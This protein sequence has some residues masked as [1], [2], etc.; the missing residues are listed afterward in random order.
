LTGYLV[1]GCGVVVG[2]A[3]RHRLIV[4]SATAAVFVGSLFLYPLI[5]RE[6]F[7][8]VDAGQFMVRVRAPSGTRIEETEKLIARVE[9]SIRDT[10][11]K[12]DL[13]MLISN[14]G[15]LLDW[16]AAYTPNSGPMDAFVLVQLTHERG[17][18]AQDYANDLRQKLGQDF[19]GIEFAFETGGMITAAL[20]F[21]LP[22]PIN[23]QVEG[24]KLDVAAKV[25]QRIKAL[26]EQVPGTADVRIQQKLDY[27]QIA[28]DVD[29]TRAAYCGLTQQDVVKNIVT[30][31]NSS[32][33]FSPS[34]W[35][36][37]KNGNHYFI[38]AQYPETD[39]V[40]MSTLEHIPVSGPQPGATTL[41]KNIAKFRRTN[42]PAEINHLN[43][44]RVT[45]IFVNIQ[46][47]DVGSVAADIEKSLD[48]LRTE[49]SHEDEVAVKA[50]QSK[51]WE[52]Y[53]VYMRGEVASMKESFSSLGFGLA[54]ASVLVYLVM[55]AQF[56]SFVDP[57][58]VMFAVP[59]GLI[60]VLAT[61]F[62]TGTSINIQSFM[63]VIFMVGIA[64]SNSVL[65][66]DF[67]NRSREEKNLTR[68][69]AALEGVRIRLRPIL[70]TSLA[71]ILGL[72]PMA[73]GFGRGSEA[74]IPLAR[75]V[76]GGLTV[77]TVLVIVFVPILYTLLKR[78]TVVA[79][80]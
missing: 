22:S 70:M 30:A 29:R 56:R 4:V 18:S 11:P 46:G 43:I 9:T 68:F 76:V 80:G 41:L 55:V 24:N 42:A 65:L 79:R 7:P 17:R 49:M 63:G 73:I 3:L 34:F 54:L 57:F 14:T 67:A 52:G 8:A 66:V 60:G 13:S 72:L 62:L 39:I 25:A 38:G 35:I 36:D 10:I 59:L 1:H 33:N 44:N 32:V 20:N 31:F 75:A 5:G 64:V 69:E 26:C 53:R 15:V 74:N 77:S 47:R 21:G 19:P 23:I 28:V 2:W 58:I 40:S 37:N 45:D 6:L 12:P 61:L 48:H 71:A 27:P 51:P 78:D 16:P 50:G